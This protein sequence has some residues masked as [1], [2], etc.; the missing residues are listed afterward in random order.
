MSELLA[1]IGKGL[2]ER[3]GL[4]PEE[5]DFVASGNDSQVYRRGG[6][7]VKFYCRSKLTLGDLWRYQAEMALSGLAVMGQRVRIE[8]HTLELR[9]NPILCVGIAEWEGR[10]I[11]F[12]VSPFIDLPSLTKGLSCQIPVDLAIR[13]PLREATET[14]RRRTGFWN[15]E[16]C[17]VN[18]KIDPQKDELII[19]DIC[20]RIGPRSS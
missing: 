12:S 4:Y 13:Q 15:V 3:I 9:V 2:L 1:K 10:S 18:C 17:R 16:I 14:I 6:L 11:P 7:A 8:E 20:K 5:S 19:T